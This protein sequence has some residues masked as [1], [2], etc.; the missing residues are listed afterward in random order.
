MW[1]LLVEY[2]PL[3]VMLAAEFLLSRSKGRAKPAIVD[4]T[5]RNGEI[6]EVQ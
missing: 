3:F 4:A 2:L 5:Y 6:M 1:V